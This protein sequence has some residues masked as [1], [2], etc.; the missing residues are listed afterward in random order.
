EIL[1]HP[2]AWRPPS[3]GDD[4]STGHA[5]KLRDVERFF[6][7]QPT[8]GEH[9]HHRRDQFGSI[10]AAE[11]HEDRSGKTFQIGGKQASAAVGTEVA[12]EPLAGFSDIVKRLRLAAEEREI[13]FRHTKEGRRRT[14]G[15]L[16]AVVA[17]A[18]RDEARIRIE[19][20]LY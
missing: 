4:A 20:E 18:G 6:P 2:V 7:R 5:G 3:R 10:Q 12:I 15:R 13:V 17:M 1:D 19:P 9:L 8:L 14:A 11:G 16:L